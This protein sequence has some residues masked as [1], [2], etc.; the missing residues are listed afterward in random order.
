M[1]DRLLLH[2]CCAP[3][4]IY[5]LRVLRGEGYDVTGFFYNPNI[6]PYGEF[7]RRLTTLLEYSKIVL[8]P[9]VVDYS[10]DLESFLEGQIR[11]R[12]DRCLFCYRTRLERAFDKA[13]TDG[14]PNL[15]TTLLYS[16]YQKHERIKEMCEEISKKCGVNFIYIDFRKGW[17]EGV[18]ESKALNM[19]RQN[20]CGCIFS[21][22]E[23]YKD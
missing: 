16:K 2:I 5:P 18:I 7:K 13:K 23:R 4:L 9:I 17:K 12:D 19:Y 11:N 20:Y 3:C 15:T 10:Y 6:H 14:F 21:E 1:R 22:R 8:L